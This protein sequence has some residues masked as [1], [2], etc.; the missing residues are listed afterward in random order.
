MRTRE[1]LLDMSW[2]VV[3]AATIVNRLFLLAV[4]IGLLSSWIYGPSF[5]DLLI[6]PSAGVDEASKL[7]G[8]RLEMMLGLA[9]TIA[10]DRLLVTLYAMIASARAGDP[11]IAINA[12]R[13]QVIGWCL[14]FLQ[15]LDLPAALLARTFLS[16][17]SA[18]PDVG[19]SPGGWVAV[20]MVFVLSRVFA[21]GAAM[22]DDL[23]GTI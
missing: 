9:M 18:A 7:V 6:R 20:L 22:R 2:W 10:T 12:R 11:F 8:L 3:R 5:A 13:L 19:F 16:L 4:A 15:L 23:E 1:A 17:G 14:L 21:A